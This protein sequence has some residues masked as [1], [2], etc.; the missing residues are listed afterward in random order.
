MSEENVMDEKV[1]RTLKLAVIGKDVSKS[2]SPPMH[3]FIAEH[4]GNCITYD[5]VSI[6]P[7]DFE[8]TI[9]SVFAAY[10]GFN[11]TIPF[12]LTIIPRLSGTLGDAPVYG[13]VNT[14]VS[15]TRLGYNTDGLGFEMMVKN[16]GVDVKGKDVLLLGCGG[17][18][19]SV[20]KKLI[21]AGAHM[22]VY[23]KFPESAKRVAAEFGATVVDEVK[24]GPYYL[25]I[26]ATGIGMH[27]SEGM[28]PA[29]EDVIRCC[30]VALDLIYTPAESEFLRLARVNGKKTINGRA[31][32]FYQAY[33]SECIY[34]DC[35][36]DA[37]EAKKLFELFEPE[38][39]GIL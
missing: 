35:E 4:M 12:K 17:A 13:A 8:S 6:N 10:D 14:V 3:C 28:S 26:N 27:T 38:F 9:E 24:P 37:D 5:K 23:D 34:F 21:D 31:M 30:E 7:D 19:R 11:V 22:Y 39:E 16:N 32:L 33:F 2:L 15:S 18:G 1:K 25:I 20:C 29:G 36:P